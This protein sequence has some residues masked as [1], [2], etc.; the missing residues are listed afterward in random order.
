MPGCVSCRTTYHA[1]LDAG[2]G[3]VLA[4]VDVEGV[5]SVASGTSRVMLGEGGSMDGGLVVGSRP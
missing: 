2:C 5:L 3:G 4:L 1:G